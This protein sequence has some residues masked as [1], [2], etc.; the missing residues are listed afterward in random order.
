MSKSNAFI[1]GRG[2]EVTVALLQPGVRSEVVPQT[3]TVGATAAAAAATTITV[4]PLTEP[5]FASPENPV[6]LAFED[7]VDE[8]DRFVKVIADAADGAT[9]LTVDPLKRGIAAASRG[10]YPVKLQARTSAD[11]STT[12]NDTTTTTFDS[13]GY[14][15]GIVTSIGYGVSCPGNFLQL[16][17]GFRT[18][19]FAFNEFREVWL[20]LKLPSPGQGYTS[21]YIFKGPASVTDAPLADPADGIITANLTFAIRG[22]LEIEEPA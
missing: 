9:T 17:A 4:T 5:I 6:F 7:A 13:S 8:G 22:K 2:T 21:G 10:Q 20:T 12:A 14:V 3:I 15:D 18:C 11:L 1:I 19:F 16:D